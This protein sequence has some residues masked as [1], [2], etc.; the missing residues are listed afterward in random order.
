[1]KDKN[2]FVFSSENNFIP[3][4]IAQTKFGMFP[5]D[6]QCTEIGIEEFCVSNSCL[7][8]VLKQAAVK[9]SRFDVIDI[10]IVESNT[11]LRGVGKVLLASAHTVNDAGVC[12]LL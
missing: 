1:M 11:F 2:S 4:F 12:L 7:S 10:F 3:S 9:A 6:N 5:F 8:R